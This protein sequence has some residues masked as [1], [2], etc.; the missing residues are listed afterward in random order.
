M[1]A[2]G[3]VTTP[4]GRHVVETY[5]DDGVRVTI[6]GRRIIDNWTQHA[7]TLDKAELQLTQGPHTVVVEYY[8]L[9]GAAKLRLSLDPLPRASQLSGTTPNSTRPSASQPAGPGSAPAIE[10]DEPDEPADDETW[11]PSGV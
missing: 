6:D 8:Q 2:T 11:M 4:A 9:G 3:T 7:P 1:I 10:E 5:S